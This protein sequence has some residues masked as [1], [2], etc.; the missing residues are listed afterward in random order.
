M[1]VK[2][3]AALADAV[4]QAVKELHSYQTPSFMVL[5]VDSVDADY[6]AWIVKETAVAKAP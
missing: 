6:Q 3:R 5:P 2:T 1:I 4:R